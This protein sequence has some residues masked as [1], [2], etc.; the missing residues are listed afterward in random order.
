M[1]ILETLFTGEQFAIIIASILLLGIL[2]YIST[3]FIF[4]NKSRVAIIERM[5]KYV[6]TYG[7]KL[8]YFAP[9]IYRRVG[10]YKVGIIS[11]KIVIDRKKYIVQFEILNFKQF[12][13]V[14]NHDVT[15]ILK[16]SLNEKN[17]DLSKLLIERFKFCGA[18]FI[19]LQKVK[20]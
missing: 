9:L 8:Y 12:H 14:G 11:Q 20:K 10:Y 6:G 1:N 3:G 4:V 2:L 17:A 19:S 16:A 5:G 15:G 18:R 7:P 13:Y